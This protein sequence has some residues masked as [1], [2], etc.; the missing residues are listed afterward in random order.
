MDGTDAIRSLLDDR[1][2]TF[3][4]SAKPLPYFFTTILIIFFIYS[5][6]GSKLNIP[7]INQK[8]LYELTNSRPKRN[9]LTNARGIMRQWF[10]KNPNKP[11]R[12]ISDMGET[13]VLPPSMAN[14]IRN[15]KNLSFTEFSKEFFQTKYPGFNAFAEGNHDSI[16]L[17]VINKDLTKQL[18]KVTE[19]LA[20][21]TSL[22]LRDIFTENKDW[23]AIPMRSTVLHFIA[24]ISSRVFLG[25][26]L[27]RNKSWL[28][29]TK[30]YTLNGFTAADR[31]REYPPFL[32]NFVHWFLPG[33]QSARK[34]IQE[35]T[36][37]IKPIVDKRHALKAQAIA[38][39]RSVPE[40]HDAIEW[41][42]QASV[43]KG[44][45]HNPALSQLFLSTVAIHTTTDLLG[46][47][48][49]DLAKH[50]EIIKDLQKEVLDVLKDGGWKKTSLYSMKLL[51][52][53]IKESQRIKPLQ[54]ASM[55]RVS[56]ADV[57]LSDGTFI[58][59]GTP[60]CVSSH[61]LWDPEVYPEPDKWDGYRFY[62]MREQA[63]KENV[64]QLVSTSPEHLGFGHGK[65]A[66]PGRFF[67][68]N[69]IKIALA[70]I[71]LQYEWRIPAGANTDITDYGG[72]P[73]LN[74]HL[75]LE[76]RR[77]AG[78]IDMSL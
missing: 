51:D 73:V 71:L 27:C 3:D 21:E 77:R 20:D 19:P 5:L 76:I 10:S 8:K 17:V 65:H 11:T 52:S 32:R 49:V 34:Q 75:E 38:E 24:R 46:Q 41:F 28:E 69:E 58:P 4:A 54:I 15:H 57:T 74:P 1:A 43:S 48:L 25:T 78:E 70:H 33:C 22:A 40:Y 29:I 37:I 26:E 7:S 18:A 42:E 50:P 61:A 13:I 59:T 45:P 6:Q 14:E 72:N 2:F 63:N 16:T 30:N 67:A 31:L 55:Q 23:H 62:R 56:T 35:A 9:Y 12:L 36:A 44:T 47:V 53:V 39:G 64:S 66:C 60:V 68:A